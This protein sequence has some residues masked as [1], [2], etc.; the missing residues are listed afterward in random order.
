[1]CICASS[2]ARSSCVN[3]IRKL[4]DFYVRF[5]F[6]CKFTWKSFLLI[7]LILVLHYI[8]TSRYVNITVLYS[9]KKI[10]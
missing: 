8:S 9:K 10:K 5:Y 6:S 3:R 4:L 7:F 1:M 2:V